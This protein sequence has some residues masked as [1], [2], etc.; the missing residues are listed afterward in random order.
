MKNYLIIGGSSGIGASLVKQLQSKGVNVYSTYNKNKITSPDKNVFYHQLDVTKEDIDL[1][2]LPD[3]IDGFAYC[4]GSINLRPFHR[5]E[6]ADF[7]QDYELQVLGAIKILQRILPSLKK[8]DA[9]S[10]LF[11]S[12]VAVQTGFNFHTQVGTSK[13]AI[14]GLTKSLAAEWAPKIRVNAIAPSI[15]NTPLTAKLLNSDDKIAA[16]AARHP[17]KKVGLP[18]DIAN[19]AS[20]L[21]SEE[22][23]WI[24][25]QIISVDGGISSIKN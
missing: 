18:E 1:S 25:G 2:F 14:E 15:T 7:L 22:S 10:V 9:A 5:I 21:L 8:S 6:P 11:F 3:Q 12:T 24:T 13:G 20:F 16:N 17:L 4:P 19:A 23:S